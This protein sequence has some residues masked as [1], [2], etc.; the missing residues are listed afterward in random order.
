[1]PWCATTV[2][3]PLRR[4]FTPAEELVAESVAHLT[5]SFV[6]LDTSAAAVPYLLGGRSRRQLTP[7]SRSRGSL[8]GSHGALANVLGADTAP[9]GKS[10]PPTTSR[11]NNS[12]VCCQD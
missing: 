2:R 3:T 11:D 5:I 12:A 1:M 6:G 7:S 9:G 4:W 8:T 10:A